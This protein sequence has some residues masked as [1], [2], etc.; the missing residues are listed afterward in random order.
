MGG[1]ANSLRSNKASR[2]MRA[3]DQKDGRQ[4]AVRM[5]WE[6]EG[7]GRLAALFTAWTG[8]S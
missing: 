8:L 2:G 3:S 1:L 4:A 6:I 5:K 7:I